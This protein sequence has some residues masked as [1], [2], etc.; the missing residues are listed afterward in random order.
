MNDE[1]RDSLHCDCGR[2]K[3]S[4]E[5]MCGPCMGDPESDAQYS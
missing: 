5:P 3:S 1:K 4:T 2:P